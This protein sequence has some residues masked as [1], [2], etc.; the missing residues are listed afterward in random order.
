M[1]ALY[2]HRGLP[3]GGRSCQCEGALTQRSVR[4]GVAGGAQASFL[5]CLGYPCLDHQGLLW[6][7]GDGTQSGPV[8]GAHGGQL[9]ISQMRDYAG[10]IGTI[11]RSH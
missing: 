9:R 6:S 1:R 10:Q 4:T 3:A 11:R 2:A 7:R 5:L 8:E